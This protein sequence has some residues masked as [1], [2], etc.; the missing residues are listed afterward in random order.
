MDHRIITYIKNELANEP[1]GHIEPEEDLV[2]SGLVD[3]LGMM[4]LIGYIEKEF[5]VKIGPEDMTVENFGTLQN[6]ETYLNSKRGTDA[7]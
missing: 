4:R 2:G 5:D 6:I 3:S 7:A 1:V